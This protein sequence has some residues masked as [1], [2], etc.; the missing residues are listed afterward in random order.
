MHSQAD[1]EEVNRRGQ[2]KETALWMYRIAPLDGNLPSPYELLFN[3]KPRSFIPGCQRTTKSRH[4]EN[5][6]HIEQNQRRQEDQARFYNKKATHDRK[7]FQPGEL[8]NI[9]NTTN[10]EWEPGTVV[11]QD[12]QEAEP[13]TYTVRKGNKDYRRPREH[14]KIRNHP[15]RAATNTSTSRATTNQS[16]TVNQQE[17]SGESQ[18]KNHQNLPTPRKTAQRNPDQQRTQQPTYPGNATTVQTTRYGRTVK[19]PDRLKYNWTWTL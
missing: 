15:V 18:N 10:K 12:Q 3:R 2:S 9:Y 5:D 13:R 17:S 4:P 6:Q 16:P 1:M 8:V 7:P 11:R 19:M 14:L